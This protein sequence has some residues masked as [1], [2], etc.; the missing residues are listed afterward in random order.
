[1]TDANGNSYIAANYTILK[2]DANG[3]IH[4]EKVI[5]GIN[6]TQ[7]TMNNSELYMTGEILSNNLS[8]DNITVNLGYFP[9]PFIAKAG[10]D[11]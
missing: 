10:T 7:V 4:T 3:A 8:V 9:V 11:Y 5:P 1:M 2:Y 6:I